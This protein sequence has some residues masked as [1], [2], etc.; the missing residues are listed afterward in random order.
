MKEK[1]GTVFS[2]ADDNQ[3]L[4]GCTVSKEVSSGANPITYFSLAPRTDISAEIHPFHKFIIVAQGELEVFGE[5]GLEEKLSS[6]QSIVT[7]PDLAVGMRSDV[8][9]IYTEIEIGKDDVMNELVEPNKVFKLGDL[10]DYQDHKVVNLDVVKNDSMKFVVMAFDDGTGLSEHTA[11]A[12][13]LIFALD[14]EGLITYEGEEHIIKAG[15][16]F[17]FANG[18]RHKID[19]KGRF[20]MGLLL[21][22][23]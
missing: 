18:G 23:N 14:G 21:V 8:G 10:V 11:P 12:E 2:I 16:N 9:T 7:K 19:A 3:A 4:K 5:G 17:H 13:A 15:E 20:K 22:F 6:G 1:V